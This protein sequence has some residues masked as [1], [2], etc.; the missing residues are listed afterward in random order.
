MRYLLALLL[1][2]TVLAIA[3]PVAASGAPVRCRNRHA[4][5]YSTRVLGETAYFTT[6]DGAIAGA[7]VITN[8]SGA[9]YVFD[10][11]P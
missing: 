6:A 8:Q 5:K 1:S 10:P 7:I 3:Q 9:I 4:L 11:L 2:F